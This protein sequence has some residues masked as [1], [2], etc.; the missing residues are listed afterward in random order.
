MTRDEVVAV[1]VEKAPEE[2]PDLDAPFG[3]DSLAFVEY[4]MDVE[5]ALGV[6]LDEQEV[7]RTQTLEDLVL[8]CLAVASAAPRRVS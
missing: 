7:S 8:L 3:G 1:L 2:E 6:E 4:V 5:D